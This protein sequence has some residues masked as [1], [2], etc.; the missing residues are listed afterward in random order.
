MNRRQF[1]AD[2]C[3]VL[4]GAGIAGL[5]WPSGAPGPSPTPAGSPA[6]PAA[7][8]RFDPATGRARL[9]ELERLG[10][11]P[12]EAMFWEKTSDGRVR[13]LLCPTFCTLRP[14]ERGNCRVRFGLENRLVTVVYGRPCSVAID[15]IEKKPVFHY[16][17]GSTSF[18]LA[19]AGCLLSCR[20][21][22]NWQISQA[23]P[24]S[25]EAYDL[26]PAQVV[27]TAAA[28]GCRTIAYTYTEPTI[29]YEYMFDTARL[30]K[31]RGIGNVVVSCGYLNPE[32]LAHLA[33]FLD[34][35][36]VDLK[37]FTER[38]YR[39]V[40]GGTLAPVLAT[41]QG[42]ART[43]VLIDIVTLVVPTLNDDEPTM[44]AM[45]TWIH[46]HLGPDVS[47]F[48]SR[49][50]PTFQLRNLPPTPVATLERLRD[51]A[52]ATGLRY[53]YLGNVPGH[54]AESTYCPGCHKLLI[55]RVGYQLTERHISRGACAF[56][57][58]AIPGVWE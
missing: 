20:Y 6:P 17:P 40:C 5:M 54:P 14:Y 16:L 41:L 48:L 34:V 30:A 35:M 9:A 23:D 24:E 36:K 57:G 44:T 18:S 33:P 39:T 53:V 19:T 15:P 51:L 12:R 58:H 28:Q 29:F 25:L 42:L 7:A 26:A 52:L 21:C 49:F 56:C 1:L 43:K 47:L 31:A 4:G 46:Q 32:P 50:Y 10:F 27:E 8:E 11:H 3:L 37:G 45:F 38:F 55:G 22:Q 2:L 13:C